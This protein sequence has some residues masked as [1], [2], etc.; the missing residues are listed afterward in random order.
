MVWEAY[1]KVKANRGSAGIDGESLKQF[2]EN[3]SN[4]LY[5]LWNRL[6]SGSYFP[7]P[8]KEV[9]FKHPSCFFNTR[10]DMARSC[11]LR[12]LCGTTGFYYG[13]GDQLD[14][15]ICILCLICFRIDVFCAFTLLKKSFENL[16]S[17]RRSIW[18][19]YLCHL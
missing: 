16:L 12:L 3:L 11:S 5:K 13:K 1:K 15:S 8:V 6:S 19:D 4:N 2:E 14:G 17:Q 7:P 18:T 10:W 9:E